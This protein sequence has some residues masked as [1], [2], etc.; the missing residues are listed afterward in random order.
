MKSKAVTPFIMLVCVCAG[1]NVAQA[2]SP[3]D[4][5]H[6][7]IA[8]FGTI[9]PRPNAAEQPQADQHYKVV[10]DISSASDEADMLNAGLDHVA[11]AVNVFAS[12]GVP[13]DDLDFVAVVHGPATSAV[14]T[15]AAYAKEVGGKN[16]NTALIAALKHAGV[17]IEV[18]GQALADHHYA[19]DEVNP[20]VITTLSALST[21]AI[22]GDKG[23]AYEKL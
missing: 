11:R 17:K 22:Y 5:N 8:N 10:F 1:L 6:P 2:D 14:L 3:N 16:P 7:A 15:D 4:P 12:A 19:D 21:L 9:H 23:Y 18:C 20:A 13:V